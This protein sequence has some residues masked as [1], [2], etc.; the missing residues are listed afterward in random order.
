MNTAIGIFCLGLLIVGGWFV[1]P[2]LA[3]YEYVGTVKEINTYGIEGF[4]IRVI[5]LQGIITIGDSKTYI[6]SPLGINVGDYVMAKGYDRNIPGIGTVVIGTENLARLDIAANVAQYSIIPFLIGLGLMGLGAAAFVIGLVATGM[7]HA[8]NFLG[9][10]WASSRTSLEFALKLFLIL[11]GGIAAF[12]YIGGYFLGSLQIPIFVAGGLI[13][14]I[15][16]LTLGYKNR[17]W[18]PNSFRA[19]FLIWIGVFIF[20]LGYILT[21]LSKENIIIP[22]TFGAFM[23]ILF[24]SVKLT[25]KDKRNMQ[26]VIERALPWAKEHSQHIELGE[27]KSRDRQNAFRV[28]II[29]IAKENGIRLTDEKCDFI[30]SKIDRGDWDEFF[31]PKY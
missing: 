4:N 22:I 18:K 20:G 26:K 6:L 14:I 9:R 15:S 10:L 27:V 19:M 2:H 8:G 25:Q 16:S 24:F 30:L 31:Q 29:P 17:D 1:Y 13:A 5:T 3:G 7:Q 11:G 21:W 23:L 12:G 28:F